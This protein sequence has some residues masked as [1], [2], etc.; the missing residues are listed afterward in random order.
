[1]N[2]NSALLSVQGR[3]GV[4]RL[5]KTRRQQVHVFHYSWLMF[6][7]TSPRCSLVKLPFDCGVISPFL[8]CDR[9]YVSCDLCLEW[10]HLECLKMSEREIEALSTS[11][12][13]F[14]PACRDLEDA[15]TMVKRSVYI[16]KYNDFFFL[17]FNEVRQLILPVFRFGH[18]L[19]AYCYPF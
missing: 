8:W 2:P 16:V 3:S 6:I 10:F 13:F 17:H 18:A 7:F 11:D 14:C 1:M 5:P 9:T 4:L 15:S 12:T 19:T